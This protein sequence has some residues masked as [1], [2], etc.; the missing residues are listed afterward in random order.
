MRRLRSF[1][2]LIAIVIM[3]TQSGCWSS[4]EIEDLAVYIGIALDK[5]EPTPVEQ[6][7]EERGG[8]YSKHNKI[9]ATVQ[10]VPIKSPSSNKETAGK[11]REFLNLSET[12]DSVLEIFRQFSIRRD[13]P[14]IGHHLKVIVVSA[15]LLEEQQI[16]QV[17]DFVLRDN[18]IRPST[19]VFLSTG[20]AIDTLKTNQPNEI[21]AFHI[22]DMVRNQFRT[23]KVMS[24]IILS[25]LDALMHSKRSFIL[26]NIVEANGELQFSG[27]GIVKG[28]SGHWIGNI[29]Q[30]DVEC[31]SWLTNEGDSGVIKA[32]SKNGQPLT[33]EIKS[34]KSRVTSSVVGEDIAFQVHIQSEGRIIEDWNKEEDPSKVS[35]QKEAE[36]IFKKKLAS[37]MNHLMQAMQSKYKAEVAGFGKALSIQ[38]PQVWKKIKEQWDDKFSEIPVTVSIDLKITDFGSST[39]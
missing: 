36:R 33:Y 39:K 35:Y 31:I 27:A 22:N 19:K 14:I 16:A 30:E 34:M 18:D 5:S 15:K 6:K 8:T 32:D 21:P 1:P 10:I 13:R 38:Q 23:S 17:M 26:Q 9:T 7:L 20:R 4:K 29:S 12:G 28:K 24:P 2:F 25:K 11:T 37:M 3:I